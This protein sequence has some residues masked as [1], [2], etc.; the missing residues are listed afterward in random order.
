MILAKA[1]DSDSNG[2]AKTRNG[3]SLDVDLAQHVRRIG[4][5]LD[6]HLLGGVGLAVGVSGGDGLLDD[7]GLVQGET[8]EP[9]A[10]CIADAEYLSG[11]RL[12]V[13]HRRDLS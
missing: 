9:D 1:V 5:S 10:Q 3:G 7:A 13:W 2:P 6:T 8:D 4:R 11:F 12:G